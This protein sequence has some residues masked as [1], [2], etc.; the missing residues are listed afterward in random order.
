MSCC[1]ITLLCQEL[2]HSSIALSGPVDEAAVVQSRQ[3]EGERYPGTEI[4]SVLNSLSR[5]MGL[6]DGAENKK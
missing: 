5:E 3:P 2:Q 4:I 6:M 1:F